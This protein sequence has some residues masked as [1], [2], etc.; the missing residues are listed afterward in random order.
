MWV[1][2]SE[3]IVANKSE[4]YSKDEIWNISTLG[5]IL[6]RI[7]IRLKS[8]GISIEDERKKLLEQAKKS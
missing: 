7:H 6:K 2:S 5:D 8:E 4:I 1:K 3:A